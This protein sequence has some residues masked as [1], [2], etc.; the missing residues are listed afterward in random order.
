MKRAEGDLCDSIRW[1]LTTLLRTGRLF[2]TP[3]MMIQ[4]KS[5]ILSY[6]EHRT[7]AI[8]H[9]DVSVLD[10][11][12]KQYDRF[13]AAIGLTRQIALESFFLAPFC[14][15][16]D[17]AML[18]VIHRCVLGKGPGQI[19]EFLKLKDGS[20]HPSGRSTIRR[21]DKQIRSFRRGKFFETTAKSILGLVDIYNMLP[22]RMVDEVSV[23]NFQKKYK[24][25]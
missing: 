8:Y 6:V 20:L 2:D 3:T 5:R 25:C 1:K 16:R 23:Q 19:R 4:F 11:V 12:D 17:M 13:L 7:A 10:K 24:D 14:A 9:A 18:G 22:Q 21:H 15:R